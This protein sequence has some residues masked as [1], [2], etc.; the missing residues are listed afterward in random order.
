M[1][2]GA[3]LG[4]AHTASYNLTTLSKGRQHSQ[5]SLRSIIFVHTLCKLW[6]AVSCAQTSPEF[7]HLQDLSQKSAPGLPCLW[8]CSENLA[9]EF[10]E[11]AFST[12]L[13][14]AWVVC[15]S[16]CGRCKYTRDHAIV[17]V[18]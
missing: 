15:K 12:R 2:P 8:L 5:V 16:N 10:P 4:A 18:N 17:V 11:A 14:A 1:T 6:M 7:L 13:T 3:A 9:Q